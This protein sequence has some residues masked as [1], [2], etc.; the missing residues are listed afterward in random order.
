M[1]AHRVSTESRPGAPHHRTSWRL[2]KGLR[3]E[4]Q[5]VN[6]RYSYW[7]L[8]P[9]V[10]VFTLFFVLPAIFGV[11]LS[12]TDAT[13]LSPE[14]H[15]VGLK[16][17]KI[18]FGA[19]RPDL[20]N[21]TWNQFVFAFFDT[22]TKLGIGILLAFILDRTFR[23]RS[24]VRALVYLPIMF[25]PIVIG[26]LFTF[27]LKPEGL[28]NSGL[29]KVGLGALA[30][31]WLGS[32]DLAMYS[33]IGIDTW[34]GVGWTVVVVL[35]ALQAIPQDVME[36]ALLDGATGWSLTWRIKIPFIMHAINL[37]LVLT[38]VSGMKAFD[39]FYATT[40]GG[41][42][43]A[44]EV[45]TTYAAKS[46]TSGSL[47]YPSAVTVVQFVIVTVMALVANRHLRRREAN[48]A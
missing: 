38:L 32:F 10:L 43:D 20:W 28:L 26:I 12:V 15:F 8:V 44:T 45:M 11:Y 40:K 31:D 9:A 35:A 47:S 3:H 19:D 17:Y 33:V 23:G 2:W 13:V 29:Q 1:A 22:I 30:K 41:P 25:S 6:R 27:I 36:A 34:I 39:I 24:V 46:L 21:A 14:T 37:A 7:F 5:R 4:R 42:G 18:L 48:A 16:V